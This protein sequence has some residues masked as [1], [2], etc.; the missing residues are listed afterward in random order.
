M[1]ARTHTIRRPRTAKATC[2]EKRGCFHALGESDKAGAALK[3]APRRS[4]KRSGASGEKKRETAWT[5]GRTPSQSSMPHAPAAA[6]DLN[7]SSPAAEA[8]VT[9]T[10]ARMS[11]NIM[12]QAQGKRARASSVN[13]TRLS[14]TFR[15]GGNLCTQIKRPATRAQEQQRPRRHDDA[16]R[17]RRRRAK[18]KEEKKRTR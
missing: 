12:T 1:D 10:A 16:K 5:V 4:S 11:R 3:L 2:V 9:A 14:S 8:A 17:Q 7:T 6:W 18:T 13:S 15:E